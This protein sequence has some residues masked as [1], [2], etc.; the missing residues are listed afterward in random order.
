MVTTGLNPY[1]D[2]HT[3]AALDEHSSTLAFLTV[4]NHAEGLTQLYYF[5]TIQ[6]FS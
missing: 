4:T 2:S 5:R 1:P 6:V 3:V